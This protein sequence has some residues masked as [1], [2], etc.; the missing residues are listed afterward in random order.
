MITWAVAYR[1]RHHAS[2]PAYWIIFLVVWISNTCFCIMNVYN[3]IAWESALLYQIAPSYPQ[4]NF[5]L[6]ALGIRTICRAKHWHDKDGGGGGG[7]AE[8]ASGVELRQS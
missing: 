2:S 4:G 6:G 3:N 7:G 1:F 5:W 8:E